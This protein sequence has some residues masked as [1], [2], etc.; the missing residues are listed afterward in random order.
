MQTKI[1][2]KHNSGSVLLL[3]ATA[4]MSIIVFAILVTVI[5]KAVRRLDGRPYNGGMYTNDES[6]IIPG[7]KWDTNFVCWFE[8]VE[9]RWQWDHTIPTGS[10]VPEEPVKL[11]SAPS[12][13]RLS[14]AVYGSLIGGDG[15]T[16]RILITTN[17]QSEHG[18]FTFQDLG[19]EV[20]E[21]GM[22]IDLSWTHGEVPSVPAMDYTLQKSSNMIHWEDVTNWKVRESVTN[23]WF[24]PTNAGPVFFRTFKTYP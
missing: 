5:I 13:P 9:L 11:L 3:I 10:F 20:D 7:D 17:A 18:E 23:C 4:T 24:E 15:L 12:N 14:T 8:N 21:N 1:N 6:I 22:P 2:K 19:M 16:L